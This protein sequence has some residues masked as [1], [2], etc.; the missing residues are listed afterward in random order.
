MSRNYYRLNLPFENPLRPGFI[1]PQ[2]E[3]IQPPWPVILF[4]FM[5]SFSKE[6]HDWFRSIK[7]I[8]GQPHLFCGFPNEQSKIHKDGVLQPESAAINWVYSLEPS[9]SQM[10]WYDALEEGTVEV[11]KNKYREHIFWTDS[12]VKEIERYSI[13]SPTLVR[14]DV[15]HQVINNSNTHRWCISIRFRPVKSWDTIVEMLQDYI[16]LEN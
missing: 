11:L 5:H 2:I 7:C 14:I 1:F 16:I 15:P 12:Q 4:P 13:Q 6:L 10:I 3:N 8:P 9:K